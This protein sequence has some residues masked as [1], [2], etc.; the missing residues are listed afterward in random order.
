MKW[1]TWEQI[2]V[3]RMASAWLIKHYIDRDCIFEFIPTGADHASFDGIPFDIPGVKYS[4]HRGHCTFYTLI[5]EYKLKDP[6]LHKMAKIIDGADTL[7]DIAIPEE[8][9]GL[10]A[11]CSGL[12]I[13]SENDHA[14]LEQSDKIF[15]ALYVYL[16]NSS[17]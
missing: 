5:K 14:A 13:L 11:I 16:K 2:G 7:T 1:I 8:S 12:R 6:I 9:F 10:D 15:E 3:D 17:I 4:H